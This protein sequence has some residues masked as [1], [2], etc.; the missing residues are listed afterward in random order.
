MN[1]GLRRLR[2]LLIPRSSSQ[3]GQKRK[4]GRPPQALLYQPENHL[5]TGTWT[6][7]RIY[8]CGLVVLWL[9]DRQVTHR[10][11]VITDETRYFF[12]RS[13]HSL[14]L[15]CPVPAPESWVFELGEVVYSILSDRE[16]EGTVKSVEAQRC[17]VAYED[18]TDEYI[19][20]RNLR[21]RFRGTDIIEITHGPKQGEHGVIV[22]V[23]WETCEIALLRGTTVTEMVIAH[24]NH[25]RQSHPR[26][27]GGTPW[28]NERVTVCWGQYWSYT[29]VVKDAFP[30]Y[31]PHN[32]TRLEVWI[33]KLMQSIQLD[34]NN[35]YHTITRKMLKD[36]IPLTVQQQHFRQASWTD[37]VES[38]I[39]LDPLTGRRVKMHD[40]PMRTPQEPW[41]GKL[42]KII[43]GPMKDYNG[44]VVG[45]SR[46]Y[47]N[48]KFKSGVRITVSLDQIMLFARGTGAREDWDYNWVVD[49]QSGMHLNQAYPLRG[50]Q[51]FY[52]PD[53]DTVILNPKS[54]MTKGKER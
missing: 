36:A 23:W 3:S 2:V 6:D 12:N 31:P 41:L 38:N 15:H 39:I 21:K 1:G 19:I 43:Q 42:V 45:V 32:V 34:H 7:Q 30:P 24:V 48:P 26:D 53:I 5:F 13:E 22:A 51:K 37:N 49:K 29:G 9:G 52:E 40:P 35:V 27:G 47:N 16:K 33:P 25:C 10:D 54:L 20:K 46:S 8:E 44:T 14:L 11:V 18:S 17:L 4:S 50:Y 28:I